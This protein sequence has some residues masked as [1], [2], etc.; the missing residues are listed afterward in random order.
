MMPMCPMRT[1]TGSRIYLEQLP[2][3]LGTDVL[4]S[5]YDRN[6][7]YTPFQDITL[8]MKCAKESLWPRRLLECTV[9]RGRQMPTQ[10]VTATSVNAV[11]TGHKTAGGKPDF[12]R[13]PLQNNPHNSG[14]AK[15]EITCFNCGEMGHYANRC[16]SPKKPKAR[17]QTTWAENTRLPE[18]IT[19]GGE[20]KGVKVWFG[21]GCK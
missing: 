19:L 10:R 20:G 8:A 13:P 16:P 2:D 9:T 15:S 17:F 1:R 14:Q 3:P 7:K 12:S 21:G 18:S 6:H 11:D 5:C 4:K